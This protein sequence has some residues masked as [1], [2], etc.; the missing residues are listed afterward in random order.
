MKVVL[1]SRLRD[2]EVKVKLR[3]DCC[4]LVAACSVWICF[5]LCVRVLKQGR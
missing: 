3:Q 1:L 4:V 2:A 5:A